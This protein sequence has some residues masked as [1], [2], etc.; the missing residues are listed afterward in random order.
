[1]T[2]VDPISSSVSPALQAAM[3][4]PTTQLQSA[5]SDQMNQQTFL[6]L[7]VAQLQYQD[8]SKPMDSS[9]FIAQTAQF[10]VVERLNALQKLAEATTAS[11]EVLE[12]TAMIGKTVS[13][14]AA[15]ATPA[16]TKTVRIGGNLPAD[17]AVGTKVSTTATVYTKK[18]ATVPL[19]VEYTKLA[20][21]GDGSGRWEARVFLSTAQIAGP[22]KVDFDTNGKPTSSP[23][24]LTTQ[25]LDAVPGS[26]GNWDP[27]G[28]KLDQGSASDPNGLRTTAGASTVTL[29]GQDGSDGRS[30]NGIVTSVKFTANGPLLAVGN[31]DYALADVIGV[32]T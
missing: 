29:L 6:K 4:A 31:K 18:G 11:N 25:Q 7:L 2:A 3:S 23:I 5:T 19:R 13:I 15:N 10:T 27:Q 21:G 30:V 26:T 22:F 28:I 12:A 16:V 32:S 17:A 8:P 14:N 24:V 1:M 9:Q 20:N